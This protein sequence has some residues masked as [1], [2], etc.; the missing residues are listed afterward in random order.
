MA[1]PVSRAQSA[2][3]MLVIAIIAA[4]VYY[5]G[6][7][8]GFLLDDVTNIVNNTSLRLD[9]LSTVSIREA[10]FSS[11]AGILHR[12]VSML[13]FAANY[14]FFGPDPASFKS[15]N[16]VIHLLNG[17]GLFILANAVLGAHRNLNAPEL[18]A[19]Q[20]KWLVFW[21]SA[22]WTIHP[23]NLTSVL[24]VVQRMT[25]LSS[26]F[27]IAGLN[28]YVLGRI[29]RIGGRGGMVLILTS[30]VPLPVL[31]I[32]SKENG[33]L[34]PLFMLVIELAIFRF[35]ASGGGIPPLSG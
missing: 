20:L 11:D 3:F 5:P 6:L 10:A 19:K 30:A 28:L 9:S 27:M 13:S 35:R 24:Y 14:Y 18:P 25:S 16:L 1:Y 34:L 31:A 33:A 12:P 22:I 23:A 29:R 8:G 32:L 7:S 21:V 4:I 26:F 17:I 15:F 2:A